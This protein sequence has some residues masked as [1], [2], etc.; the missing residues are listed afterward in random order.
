MQIDTHTAAMLRKTSR[1]VVVK[2]VRASVRTRYDDFQGIRANLVVSDPTSF[3]T[4]RVSTKLLRYSI[5]SAETILGAVPKEQL[6]TLRNYQ[7]ELGAIR[8]MQLLE[9]RLRQWAEEQN[10]VTRREISQRCRSLSQRRALRMERFLK[11]ANRREGH[12]I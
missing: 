12:G 1:T 11:D 3:H 9:I 2:K 6:Q 5:E 4:L 8:D 7:S 10:E